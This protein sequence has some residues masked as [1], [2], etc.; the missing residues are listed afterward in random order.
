MPR[1]AGKLKTMKTLF[2]AMGVLVVMLIVVLIIIVTGNGPESVSEVSEHTRFVQGVAV[3]GVNVSGMTLEQA[4]ENGEIAAR[5]EE[6]YASFSYTFTVEGRQFTYNAQQLG[7]QRG[8]KGALEEALK[9]GNLGDAETRNQQ[10]QQAAKSGRDFPAVHADAGALAAALQAHKPEYD[11]MPEDATLK[12]A[13]VFS[14]GNNADFAEGVNGIDVN[15]A[16]LARIASESINRGDFGVIEAPAIMTEPKIT[17]DELRE[18]TVLIC[19]WA[20]YFKKDNL[21][22]EGRV[23]NIKIL[24]G[25]VNGSVIK[26]GE[27]WSIN[28]TGGKRTA[29]TA[30]VVGWK[31]AP[32]IERGRYSEQYG[33][34]VC[35]VSSTVY[36]AAIRAEIDIADRKAHSWPSS[37]IEEGMDATISS[38]GPDLKLFNQ[39][40]YPVLLASYVDEKEKSITVEV[41][42]PRLN[43]GYK[44]DFEHRKV[45]ETTP[46]P[47]VIHYNAAQTPDRKAIPEGKKID[48]VVSRKGQVWKVFKVYYDADG[49]EKGRSEFST[50]T[51]PAFQGEVY[52]NY[53]DPKLATPPPETGA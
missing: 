22:D 19:S 44:V 51:Y 6:A 3:G 10:R 23:T 14:P 53:P 9:W 21:D 42:G 49:N 4:M 32:G 7:M 36:N 26:P 27:I 17:L 29:E 30:K 13:E 46:A 15:I 52:C 33:G 41:Y 24:A 20:S 18:N 47:S 43:H 35:Q 48:W 11:V 1:R 39:Y 50:T 5:A 28:E 2:M 37:Y 45:K 12:L 25:F 40:E 38:E 8:P 16:E 31:E 34:G